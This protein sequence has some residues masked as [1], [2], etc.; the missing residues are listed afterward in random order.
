MILQNRVRRTPAI[1]I[2]FTLL[3]MACLPA[4]ACSPPAVEDASTT[5]K[6]ADLD[7]TTDAGRRTLLDR[8]SAAADRV[9]ELDAYLHGDLACPLTYGSCHERTMAIAVARIH[10]RQLSALYVAN[11]HR[12]P[13]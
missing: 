5:V 1:S 2:A 11:S 13:C 12:G 9:C 10:N 4:R 8:L 6:F 7:L 3:A